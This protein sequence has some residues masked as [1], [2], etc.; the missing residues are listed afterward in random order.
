MNNSNLLL[1]IDIMFSEFDKKS[2][3]KEPYL[4]MVNKTCY[5]NDS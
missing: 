2:L 3:I 4:F 5:V 1:K